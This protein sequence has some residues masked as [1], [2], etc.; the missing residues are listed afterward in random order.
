MPP[1]KETT[2]P[3]KEPKDVAT[4]V[5]GTSATT[6]GENG[7]AAEASTQM[8]SDELDFVVACLTH[9]V[10]GGPIPVSSSD[11]SEFIKST[12]HMCVLA[13]HQL[14]SAFLQS[15]LLFI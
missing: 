1:K 11:L 12:F 14:S 5:T 9:N 7:N 4:K 15:C 2:T 8:S 13:L 6:S 10:N 3:K